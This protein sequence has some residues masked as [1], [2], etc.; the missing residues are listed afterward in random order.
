MR[1]W[2]EFTVPGR[3]RGGL[4]SF[5]GAASHSVRFRPPATTVQEGSLLGAV[6]R[7]ATEERLV[8]GDDET[9]RSLPESKTMFGLE[10]ST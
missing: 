2:H 10:A 1:R 9:V 8:S 5:R 4:G 3:W 6:L 7:V